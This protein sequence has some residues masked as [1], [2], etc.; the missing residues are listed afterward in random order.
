MDEQLAARVSVKAAARLQM[1]SLR[2]HCQIVGLV[3]RTDLN[4]KK[5]SPQ[6]WSE[7]KGRFDVA[8]A[9]GGRVGVKPENMLLDFGDLRIQSE[10]ESSDD[11]L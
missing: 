9:G 2:P 1:Q 6:T 8:L 7:E 4:G 11:D 10:S 3:K 5:G